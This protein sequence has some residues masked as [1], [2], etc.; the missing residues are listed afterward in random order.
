MHAMR[1][2]LLILFAATVAGG[3]KVDQ[4]KEVEH[5]QSVLRANL[6]GAQQPFVPGEPL[7]LRQALDLANRQN[8]R[9]SIEGEN[10]LQ[11]LIERRRAAAAFQP[12]VNLVP[13]FTARQNTSSAQGNSTTAQNEALDVFA[14]GQINVF[15]GFS[16][17]A[18]L[19]ST[20]Q[21]IEERRNL[22]LDVQEG[23]LL[24]TATVYYDVLRAERSVE[25][26]QSSLA[27]QEA[28]VRDITGRHRA[29]MARPLDVAQTEAQASATRVTLIDAMNDVRNGRS[30]LALLTAAP[31]ADS[32]L[33][34][35]FN[36]PPSLPTVD[37]LK[38]SAAEQ[39]RDLVAAHA[40]ALASRQEVEVAVGQYYPSVTL[41]GNLFL[42]RETFPDE[43]NWDA[44]LQANLPIF[45]AGLI[46][47]DV[48]AAWSRY[49]Q[50]AM[51]ESLL[52]R[53]VLQDVQ[54]AY[55][56]LTANDDRIHELLVQVTAA[57]QAFNQADQSYTV[58]LATNLERV[59]AQDQ[60][61]SAQL[62]L[63]SARF[64]RTLS[65][66]ALARATGTLRQRLENSATM[67]ST[68]QPATTQAAKQ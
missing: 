55:Q 31:V 37:E 7:T 23:V 54:L 34:D 25:V 51:N 63:T 35:Q 64:D 46:E 42:F 16:D 1:C 14:H 67:Q 38:L 36:A 9:L 22:L 57:Q 66:L 2:L 68:T 60:L 58:G 29:G 11:A 47:A 6:L 50:A 12:T 40:G 13:T 5:Y 39:R 18:R 56:N 44:L 53:Q 15:N 10:Y 19:R 49:R 20:A 30:T 24:D 59:T 17:I 8:E 52:H 41:N 32:P 4:K 21:T 3:C 45:S 26:L 62:Q 48:R 65:F 27:V 43:R 33:I 61:L 28:R